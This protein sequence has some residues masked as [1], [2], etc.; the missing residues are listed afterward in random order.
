MSLWDDVKRAFG[1]APSR[2]RDP[3]AEVRAEANAIALRELRRL[4]AP[5]QRFGG[6]SLHD[7]A[8]DI[9]T[10]RPEDAIP[11]RR[12]AQARIKRL[13]ATNPYASKVKST[14]LNN[15]IGYG[16]T[17]T[18]GKGTPRKVIDAWQL[19]IRHA[20]WMRRLDLYGLQDLFTG[21]MLGDGD[22]FIVR[23]FDASMPGVVPTRIEV[24]DASMLNPGVGEGGIE[25]DEAGRP[26]R[27]H[28]YA[29]R[30]G[31]NWAT[32]GKPVTFE[33]KDVIHLFRQDWPGQTRGI[34]VFEPVIKRF[35]DMDDYLEAELVRK[36][37]EACFAAFITPSEEAIGDDIGMGSESGDETLNDFEIELFEPGMI[38]RLR[39]GDDVKFGEPKPSAAI[40]EF[41]RVTLLGA[42]TGAGVPY[43]HG[44]GDLSNVNYSSYRA[45]N[46]EF[47]RFCGRLQWLLII[48][49]ALEKIWDWFLQDGYELGMFAKRTY[50]IAWTP[51]AFESIDRLKDVKADVLEAG[52]LLTSRRKLIAARGWDHDELMNEI[53]EDMAVSEGLG[54]SGQGDA[55]PS[56][57][58]LDANLTA[59]EADD[60][61]NASRPRNNQE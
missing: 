21:T 35:E 61:G 31:P 2:A 39:P 47:Q 30:P 18:P 53:A 49:Q 57:A 24:L 46:L 38:Q 13:L 44:T 7:A 60:D 20:D 59:D 48:P 28:F 41:A 52:A 58:S 11:H 3:R 40:N 50:P 9:N 55:R 15:L 32:F 17:G 4:K 8:W 37:I 33:A 5:R 36:K 26:L 12:L 45:G 29:R 22:V 16:I 42:T 54:L 1:A 23:R 56:Q 6:N 25:Y 19:W 10:A 51:P 34:S 43:E 27:Y 14:L